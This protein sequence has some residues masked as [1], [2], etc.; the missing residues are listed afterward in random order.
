[1]EEIMG[2][3][4]KEIAKISGFGYGTVARALDDNPYLV[5]EETRKK[6]L[7]IA[8]K[9]NYIRDINAQAL[10]KQKTNDIGLIVP[11]I[12]G[13]AFYNDFY[14]KLISGVIEHAKHFSYGTRVLLLEDEKGFQKIMKDIK[15]MKL[16]GVIY[17]S[18]YYGDFKTEQRGLKDLGVPVVVLNEYINGKKLYSVFLDDF[19]GGYDGTQYLMGLG[20][21]QIAVIRGTGRDI[22]E[23]YE[24]YKKAML[25][26]KL[27]V[28]QKYVLKADGTESTGYE[29]TLE[30]L[31][32][33]KIPTAIFALDDEMAIGAMRAIKEKGL[34]CPEDISVLGFDGMDIGKF[35][36]PRLTTILRPVTE[37]GKCAVK[38][39]LEKDKKYKK[40][41]IKKIKAIL[42]ERESC[43]RI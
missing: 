10:R 20:H 38:I 19:K 4:I 3:T 16:A 8:E 37:I 21:K 34:S 42:E 43:R 24:G 36:I 9:Y 31:G 7:K 25:D 41:K 27:K 29:K 28:Y 33:G 17:S 14:I 39:L 2:I 23:R 6:I 5:K 40:P 22:E 12:F 26:N 1:M 35:A 11:A 18:I 30:L 15:S 13:S 32:R